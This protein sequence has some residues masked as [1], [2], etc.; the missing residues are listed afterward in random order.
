[1]VVVSSRWNWTEQG[2]KARQ[3]WA[4]E[5]DR[6]HSRWR[7]GRRAPGNSQKVGGRVEAD[8][9]VGKASR[10]GSAGNGLSLGKPRG[11]GGEIPRV[12]C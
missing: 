7:E 9:G 11:R 1:M 2:W 5:R 8:L 3:G 6:M 12:R 10:T 4:G